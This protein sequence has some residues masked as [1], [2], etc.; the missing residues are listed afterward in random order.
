VLQH[1]DDRKYAVEFDKRAAQQQGVSG[2]S[3]YSGLEALLQYV[4]DITTATNIYD[5]NS[6]LLSVSAFQ[7]GACSNY[8]DAQDVKTNPGL[9]DCIVAL[10]PNAPGI[11]FPDPSA[12]TAPTTGRSARQTRAQRAR[13]QARA[14][15]QRA[16][17]AQAVR[18][19]P[20]PGS[21][22]TAAPPAT[23][24]GSP[25]SAGSPSA[26][27]ASSSG[28]AGTPSQ[29]AVGRVLDYLLGP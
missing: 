14:R 2:P 23:A 19:R 25:T 6:H 20:A 1:L 26:A 24:A 28:S 10:G 9:K 15:R 5:A 4:M 3:G 13:A 17:H 27:P 21:A 7:G 16:A 11:N 18:T 12:G 29:A 22:P 8:A